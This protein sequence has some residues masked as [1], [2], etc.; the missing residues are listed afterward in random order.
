LVE[1]VV[2]AMDVEAVVELFQALAELISTPSLE[3]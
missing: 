1:D 3:L 2:V